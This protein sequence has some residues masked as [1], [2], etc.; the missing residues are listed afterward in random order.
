MLLCFGTFFD[1]I[2]CDEL[3]VC[4]YVRL[5]STIFF[6]FFFYFF[7]PFAHAAV[8]IIYDIVCCLGFYIYIFFIFFI[9]FTF[10]HQMR[11]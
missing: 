9:L 10:I 11:V 4:S 3:F 1:L 6:F 5:N 2:S 7:I 8:H